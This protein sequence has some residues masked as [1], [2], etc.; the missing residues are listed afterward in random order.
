[1]NKSKRNKLIT[2][3]LVVALIVVLGLI[4]TT[5]A[6]VD[7]FVK[8]KE[9]TI[10][11]IRVTGLKTFNDQTV[12]SYSGLRRGQV[13]RLPGEEISGMINKLWKLELFSDINF[14][15]T[16]INGDRATLE[17][18]IEELPALSQVRVQG[19]KKGKA[20]V[21]IKDTEL[22]KGKKLSESFLTNTKNYIVNKYRKEGV[23][24]TKVVLNTIPDTTGTNNLKM[25]VNIDRGDRVKIKEFNFSGNE[26][27]SNF[28]LASKIKKTKK[29]LP[30]RFWKKSKYIEKD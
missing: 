19:V 14:Y 20:D 2:N 4:G 28:K 12:I 11:S 21:L 13:L 17:I 25:V 27:F 30:M 6:Q 10:D 18:Q 9:Y 22:T 8:G 3:R 29:R 5:H 23:L 26:R 15:L 7:Q 24:N 1:M 16:H